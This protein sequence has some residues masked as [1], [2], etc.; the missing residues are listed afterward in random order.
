M[1]AS[2]AVYDA[3]AFDEEIDIVNEIDDWEDG[4]W[5]ATASK[6]GIGEAERLVF[7]A[8]PGIEYVIE[9]AGEPQFGGFDL[10]DFLLGFSE[11]DETHVGRSSHPY[12]LTI[13]KIVLPTDEDGLPNDDYLGDLDEDWLLEEEEEE[14]AG[15]EGEEG[16]EEERMFEAFEVDKLLK[17]A[18]PFKVGAKQQGYFQFDEDEDYYQFTPSEDAIYEVNMKRGENQSPYVTLYEYD[19][20]RHD[21]LPILDLFSIFEEKAA[22]KGAVALQAN[23]TYVLQI[24]NFEGI[25]IE[26]HE[27]NV[28]RIKVAPVERSD[29]KSEPKFAQEMERNEVYEDYFIYG[30][31]Q[32]YYY[33]NEE[34]SQ[35]FTVHALPK[36]LTKKEKLQLPT[37]LDNDLVLG[38]AIIEDTNGNKKIDKEEYDKNLQF[39]PNISDPSFAVNGSFKAKQDV[40][41]FIVLVNFSDGLSLQQLSLQLH[42]TNRKDEDHDSIVKNNIP[43]KPLSLKAEK[44]KLVG[45]GYFNAGIPF[46]D[47]DYYV[48]NVKNNGEA[49][50]TLKAGPGLDGIVKVYNEKGMRV[51]NFDYYGAGDDEIGTLTVSEGKYYVEVSEAVDAPSITPYEL[52]ILLKPDPISFIDVDKNNSHYEGI[53]YWSQKGVISGYTKANGSREFKPGLP[54]SRAHTAVLFTRAL[55]LPVPKDVPAVLK[56]F[57]DVNPNHPY[58]NEI[59]ATYQSK[60]FVGDNKLFKGNDS[61]TRE[62]MASILVRAYGLVDNGKKVTADLSNVSPSH[63]E[64]VKILIQ[65]GITKQTTDFRPKIL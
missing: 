43:S 36:K 2:L 55:E 53:M 9:V 19:E 61:L 50:L 51:G 54:I 41:Y 40:G 46:G 12:E 35:I 33:K 1:D 5:I 60:I 28:E 49:T 29:N 10:L 56:N 27:F 34:A 44:G 13:E 63:K 22:L 23:K 4:D 16:E 57:T 25:S 15:E 7:E 11:E 32:Y 59:A 17:H 48:F 58:A 62:Q 45:K 38:M 26:P 47:K 52:S 8:S 39:Y 21:L 30:M 31:E 14:G 18:V 20:T 65:H 64:S 3:E 24:L 42:D 37:T 6:N